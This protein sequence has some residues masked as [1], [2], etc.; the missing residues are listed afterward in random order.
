MLK[1]QKKLTKKQIKEDK[2][3]TFY[4]QSQEFLRE[5]S[6]TILYS[7]GALV[8]AILIF[9]V[10]SSKSQEKEDN[11]I[12]ELTK[13]KIKFFASDYVGSVPILKNLAD[14][15]DGTQS[16]QDGKY[17]LASSYFQMKNYV[18]AERYFNEYL[19][20][21]A[22]DIFGPS[23]IAGVAACMEEQDNYDAAAKLYRDAA[24][25]FSE[26]FMAPQNLLN[27]ARCLV[28]AGQTDAARDVLNELLEK[29]ETS[30]VKVD[31]E[32]LL[33]ELDS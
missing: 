21:G 7:L 10:Y 23:A 11:A 3:V 28:L 4:F 30:S 8:A 33:S 12:V 32:L 26:N 13:A 29:Y 31:A 18:D 22:D 24:N 16:A 5:N 14:E 20:G 9:T 25:K 19:D 15:F 6:K 1:A 27:C 2:F 17:Y